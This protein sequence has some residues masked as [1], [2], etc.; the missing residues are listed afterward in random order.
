LG[1]KRAD[2]VVVVLQPNEQ[3]SHRFAFVSKNGKRKSHELLNP[4]EQ[5]FFVDGFSQ[6]AIAL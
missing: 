1:R 2:Q 5:L 3:A 6:E 4:L